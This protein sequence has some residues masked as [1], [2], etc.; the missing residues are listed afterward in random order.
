ME[1]FKESKICNDFL[2]QYNESIY[3]ELFPKLMKVA[4]YSLFKRYHKWEISLQEIDQFIHFF[5]YKNHN[6][7]IEES[8]NK[9]NNNIPPNESSIP[10]KKKLKKLNMRYTPLN[11]NFNEKNDTMIYI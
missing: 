6:F 8:I 3:P 1:Y 9:S 2:A 4:I 11:N 7:E 5:N 10:V